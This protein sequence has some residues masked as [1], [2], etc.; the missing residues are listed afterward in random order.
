MMTPEK[1]Q[2]LPAELLEVPL[3]GPGKNAWTMG[4]YNVSMT[5]LSMRDSLLT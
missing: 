2:A 4:A 5:N 3:A 1:M